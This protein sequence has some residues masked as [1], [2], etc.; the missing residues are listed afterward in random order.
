MEWLLLVHQIP[1]KPDYFRVKVRRR[2]QR[3][4]AVALKNSVYLLPRQ[5]EAVEDFQ[6][7]LREIQGE[8]GEAT[9]CQATL[10][11]GLTDAEVVALF[12]AERDAEYAEIEQAA[13]ALAGEVPEESP[14]AGLARLR[15]RLEDVKRTDFFDARGRVGAESALA[16]AEKAGAK[17][18]EGIPAHP[19]GV[20]GATWVT[21]TGVR[22]DRMASAW[23]IRR[24]IDSDARFRFVPG[25]EYA[26]SPGELRFDMYQGEYTHEGDRCT[27]EVLLDRFG[28]DDPALRAIGEIVHDIDCK[29]EKFERPEAPGIA[30]IV[31]GIVLTHP[32]D[33]ERLQH[34]AVVFEGL[35]AELRAPGG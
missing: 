33:A 3:I 18:A 24:F 29:D 13:R 17:P 32:G 14:E 1:P 25:K 2:L 9:L 19:H 30:A 31:N 27:F 34:G 35:F 20:R 16:Q 11:D 15:R 21:R 7:L 6:W 5:D 10:L 22:V 28:L 8:G 4:G 12:R 23:L 26:G